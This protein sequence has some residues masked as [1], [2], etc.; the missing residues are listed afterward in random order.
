IFMV[1]DI[2]G[3]SNLIY[4]GIQFN[5]CFDTLLNKWQWL[6]KEREYLGLPKKYSDDF[7]MNFMIYYNRGFANQLGLR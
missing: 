1:E 3:N 4:D 2:K 6:L 5:I 7:I